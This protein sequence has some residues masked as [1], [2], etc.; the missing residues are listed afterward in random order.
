MSV[1]PH[2]DP[3]MGMNES[4]TAMHPSTMV[5]HPAEKSPAMVVGHMLPLDDPDNPL[6]WPLHRKIYSSVVS[7]AFAFVV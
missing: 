4:T 5:E 1:Y 2:P 3:E 7:A 6:N